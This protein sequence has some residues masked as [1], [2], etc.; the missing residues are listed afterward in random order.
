MSKI[1][2]SELPK[3]FMLR[4]TGGA[5]Q[6]MHATRCVGYVWT[7]RDRWWAR[8]RAGELLDTGSGNTVTEAVSALFR[9]YESLPAND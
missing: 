1:L 5:L 3:S 8:S 6:V 4:P 9:T 7:E 2:S